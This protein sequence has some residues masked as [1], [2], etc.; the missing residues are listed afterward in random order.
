MVCLRDS[1]FL[2]VKFNWDTS[3]VGSCM[4]LGL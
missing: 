1:N 4:N 2:E 3:G